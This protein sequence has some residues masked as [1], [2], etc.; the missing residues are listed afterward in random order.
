MS[1]PVGGRRLDERVWSVATRSGP[2]VIQFV[3]GL[4]LI[5]IWLLGKTPFVG[6]DDHAGES[7]SIA[8]AIAITVVIAVVVAGV[9]WTR[10]S[11]TARGIG[12][13][14]AASALIVLIG[15]VGVAY[16]LF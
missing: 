9:L 11:S 12:L 2:V 13:S 5:A 4:V 3:L 7:A 14:V 6:R 1:T 15:G 16:I 8:M 10:S